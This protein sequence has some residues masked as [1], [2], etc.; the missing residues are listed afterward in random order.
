MLFCKNA[1]NRCVRK[2]TDWAA[3]SENGP[4]IAA[5]ISVLPSS[6]AGAEKPR[7]NV[8]FPTPKLNS[9]RTGA[10]RKC[11]KVVGPAGMLELRRVVHAEALHVDAKR[12]GVGCGDERDSVLVSSGHRG[13]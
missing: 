13:P 6:T 3:A 2:H 4:E 12:V 10:H 5:G 1:L 11:E 9:R 7:G 8:E